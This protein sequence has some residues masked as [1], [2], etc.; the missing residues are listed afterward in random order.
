MTQRPE[1]NITLNKAKLLE[2]LDVEIDLSSGNEPLLKADRW[3]FQHVKKAI[4]SGTFDDHSAQEEITK[5]KEERERLLE[6][7]DMQHEQA[8]RDQAKNRNLEARAIQAEQERDELKQQ[9][10]GIMN[11]LSNLHMTASGEPAMI[12]MEMLVGLFEQNGG[13]NFLTLTVEKPDKSKRYS[14]TIQNLNGELS[15]AEKMEALEKER[16]ALLEGLKWY[17]DNAN[18]SDEVKGFRDMSTC[19]LDAGDRARSIIAKIEK[20][21]PF[22]TITKFCDQETADRYLSELEGS[23]PE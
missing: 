10:E 14:I 17:A 15:P 22:P 5:L 21:N 8:L 20:P 19:E 23:K 9:R 13:K 11:Y 7:T 2:W 6:L 18:W 16:N 1:D 3:A 12:F 4:E